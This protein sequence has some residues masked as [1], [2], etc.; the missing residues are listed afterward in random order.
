M[1]VKIGTA[2]APP[3]VPPPPS[4]A[5]EASTALTIK[6]ALGSGGAEQAAAMAETSQRD[7][8]QRAQLSRATAATA[9]LRRAAVAIFGDLPSTRRCCCE[10]ALTPGVATYVATKL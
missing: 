8:L 2:H 10:T 4:S 3:A 7:G 6:R 1:H 9:R 5:P